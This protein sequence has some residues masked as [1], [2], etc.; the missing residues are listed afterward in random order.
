MT[1]KIEVF[2]ADCPL[3][4]E[5]LATVRSVTSECG[6]EVIERRCGGTE[7]CTPAKEYG[8][9]AVPSIVVDGKLVHTGKVSAEEFRKY[10]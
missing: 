7:C 2:T 5:T 9:T 10:I 8:I 1:P 6:C 3:C 4:L